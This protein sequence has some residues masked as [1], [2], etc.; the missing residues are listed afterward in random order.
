MRIILKLK[1]NYFL[2]YQRTNPHLNWWFK[3]AGDFLLNFYFFNKSSYFKWFKLCALY[4]QTDLKKKEK[5][6]CK[7]IKEPK[8][9]LKPLL[10][11]YFISEQWKYFYPINSLLIKTIK[12]LCNMAPLGIEDIQ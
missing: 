3:L 5:N 9:K 1:N 8:E 12:N 10:G 2:F 4:D 6:I 7:Y 11:S